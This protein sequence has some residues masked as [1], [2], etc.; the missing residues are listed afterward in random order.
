MGRYT[1]EGKVYDN[2]NRWIGDVRNGFIQL[3]KSP[4]VEMA[5]ECFEKNNYSGFVLENDCTMAEYK[6][7]SNYSDVLAANEAA[8]AAYVV[9]V[10]EGYPSSDI[11][12]HRFFYK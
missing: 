10:K 4:A 5:G 9:L 1:A 12:H 11:Q 3:V 2:D 7:P 8:A 6:V